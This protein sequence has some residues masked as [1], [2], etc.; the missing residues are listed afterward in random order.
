MRYQDELLV[1]CEVC[2]K[3]LVDF[4]TQLYSPQ[5][6]MCYSERDRHQ[7]NGNDP[8]LVFRI[9]GFNTGIRIEFAEE[10]RVGIKTNS[11]PMDKNNRKL[12]G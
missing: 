5:C 10:V 7:F 12:G 8:N 3:D 1:R 4:I 11:N 6:R 9:L 2:M